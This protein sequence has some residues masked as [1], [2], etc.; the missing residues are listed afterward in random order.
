[1]KKNGYTLTEMLVVIIV[2]GIFTITLMAT[3]SNAFKD[4]SPSYY[5]EKVIVIYKQA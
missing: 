1:M 4:N 3:T 5:D 2:L